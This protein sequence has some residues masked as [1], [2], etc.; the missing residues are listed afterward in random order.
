M[1]QRD[2]QPMTTL[3]PTVADL[4]NHH[5]IGSVILFR[6]NI[7]TIQQ[8]HQFNNQLQASRRCLPL[9]IG[10]DHEGGIVQ[11]LPM[12]TQLSGN[13]ALGATGHPQW[14]KAAGVLTGQEL[15]ALGF[16][17]NFAP[18]VDVNTHPNNPVIGVR[19][20]GSQPALVATLA[21]AYIEGLQQTGLL[22]T[23]KHFPGHGNTVVDSHSALPIIS[24]SL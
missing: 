1:P 3:P 4:I 5:G 12:A 24:Y 9:L 6:D 22:A 20:L 15:T 8:L 18:V 19:A 11:R 14:A 17:I 16:N 7:L 10:I 23:A 2:H 13:M 21:Q